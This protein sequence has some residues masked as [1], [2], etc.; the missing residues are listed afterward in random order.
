MS[1]IETR[2]LELRLENLEER[3]ITGLAVPYGQDANIGGSY[4]ERFAPGAIDSVED[5]KLFYG[6]E[7]PIGI[8]VSGRDTEGGYEITAKVSE[9]SLGN[10]VLTLMRDG[11]L[12][13]FSVGFIPVSQ[14]QD[15]STITRTKV[16]L[17]EVSVVPFPAYAGAS[18]TEVREEDREIVQ[19]TEP[20]P[21]PI[22]E[23]ESEL[24]NNIELD[25]RSV[26][27]EVAELRREIATIS[28]P[29]AVAAPVAS[30]R[31]AGEYAKALLAREDEAVALFRAAT[32]TADTVALPAFIGQINDLI[33]NNRPALNAFSSAALPAS[34]MTVEYAHVSANTLAVGVQDPENEEL[35][36]GNIAIDTVSSPVVTYGGYT[37]MSRQ[38][39]ERSTVNFVDTAIR[40]LAIQYAKAT[41]AKVI[42]TLAGLD[43]T[44]KV[45]DADGGTAA[46]LI[47]GIANGSAYI[48]NATGLNPEFILCSAD[49]Y[50]TMMKVVGS[51]GRPVVNVDGAGVNNIGSANVPGLRGSLLG[52]P[53][54][55]DLQLST[56]QVFLAN[57]AGIQTLESAGAPVRLQDGDITT[58]TESISVYGYIAA[59][60]PFEGAIVKLDVTA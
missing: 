45:F 30:Y 39:V 41:N 58:L 44:G 37:S 16:S 7:T 2:S 28:I 51:D 22:T 52:L 5:V 10:D 60:V 4:V 32:T 12:N 11:A 36:V 42:S 56:G 18:I 17:K 26:Q 24:E 49:A 35:S 27:D 46:S 20:T 3:T 1:N 38:V 50:V 40:A 54:I 55:V 6:H 13:K 23:S 15:G 33:E 29:T 14:E 19:P 53:V 47:E 8:V 21:T 31:N 57:S 48:Y 59:T 9:T 25:V 34:G 43:M